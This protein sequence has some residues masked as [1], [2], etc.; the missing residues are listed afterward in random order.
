MRISLGRRIA[1][2]WAVA[3]PCV[4]AV[5][6][7]LAPPLVSTAS[8]QAAPGTAVITGR[9]TDARSSLGVPGVTVQVEGTRLGAVTGES[10]DDVG[11]AQHRDRF[12]VHLREDVFRDGRRREQ[13]IP[14]K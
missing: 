14:L 1:R 7:L 11:R 4:A 9:V 10:R 6:A 12:L 5:I 2:C 13:S 3:L 8:A